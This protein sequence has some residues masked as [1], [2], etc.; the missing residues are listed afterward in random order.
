M[1]MFYQDAEIGAR[2][3]DL[4]TNVTSSDDL[5]GEA[6]GYYASFF[7]SRINKAA[8]VGVGLATAQQLT[9]INV[10]IFYSGQLF[11]DPSF[12][13]KGTAI[14]NATNLVSALGGLGLLH[15][16]GRKTLMVIL[17]VVVVISMLC[18]YI[19]SPKN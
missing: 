7:D 11:T 13:T 17:Q 15:V 4:E 6:P 2:L 12:K 3:A 19:F 10:L 8:W 16:A 14:I 1:K 9:G 5:S 18:L